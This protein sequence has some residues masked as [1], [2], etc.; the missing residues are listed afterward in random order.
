VRTTGR[1]TAR[2][3]HKPTGSDS[4][5]ERERERERDERTVV[6]GRRERVEGDAIWM[7]DGLRLRWRDRRTDRGTDRQTDGESD[8]HAHTDREREKNG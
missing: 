8:T 2:A 5:R 6:E 7:G 1:T 4:E 3:Q